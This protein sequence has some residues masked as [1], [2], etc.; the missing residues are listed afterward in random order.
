MW[1]QIIVCGVATHRLIKVHVVG[2]DFDVWVEDF[3][4][5]NNLFQDVSYS[6]RED[7]QRD[8][9]LIQVVKEELVALPVKTSAH[10]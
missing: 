4:L 6:S 5:A 8:A 3:G 1:G 7:E 2:E 9:V 10:Y